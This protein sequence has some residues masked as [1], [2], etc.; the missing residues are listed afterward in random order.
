MVLGVGMGLLFGAVVWWALCASGDGFHGEFGK[1]MVAELAGPAQHAPA[2]LTLARKEVTPAGTFASPVS[3]VATT[4]SSPSIEVRCRRPTRKNRSP[5]VFAHSPSDHQAANHTAP[6]QSCAISS[7]PHKQRHAPPAG[8]AA[9]GHEG[10]R[11][12]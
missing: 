2:A 3:L 8:A 5:W 10:Q 12:R 1:H 6:S 4:A 7:K 9:Q 11:T